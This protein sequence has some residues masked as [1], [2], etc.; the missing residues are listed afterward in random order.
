[1]L[2]YD[3]SDS[4]PLGRVWQNAPLVSK[5]PG[6]QT[7]DYFVRG[8]P[9]AA[10]SARNEAEI[11]RKRAT[12]GKRLKS[13]T[14]QLLGQQALVTLRFVGLCLLLPLTFTTTSQKLMNLTNMD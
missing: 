13:A 12:K 1:M 11:S 3:Q 4:D 5:C 10:T 9:C 8:S 7:Q 2:L 14:S 6:K